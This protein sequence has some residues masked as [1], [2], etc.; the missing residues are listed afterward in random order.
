[1]V[2]PGGYRA[3]RALL[4]REPPPL[5]GTPVRL[6]GETTLDAALRLACLLGPGFLAIQGPP[7]TGKS[8]TA[9][10]MIC[11]L[12]RLGRGV[13][14]TAN[15]HKVIRNLLD[16]VVEASAEMAVDLT[17]V[18]KAKDIEGRP[19]LTLLRQ[20]ERAPSRPSLEP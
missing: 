20:V 6:G 10:R 8:H 9:A 19:A 2:G 12:A 14:I 11:E 7:G 17:C 18:Q 15:S 5:K 16:K 1:M 3:A 4:L 13:G